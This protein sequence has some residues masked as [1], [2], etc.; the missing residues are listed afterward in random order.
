LRNIAP[1]VIMLCNCQMVIIVE[2]WRMIGTYT[3]SSPMKAPWSWNADP[4]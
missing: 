2:V 4:L 3:L 1:R